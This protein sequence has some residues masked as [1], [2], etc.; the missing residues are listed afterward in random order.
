[1]PGTPFFNIPYVYQL[2]G[3]LNIEALEKALSEIMCRHEAIHTIFPPVDGQ[4]IQIIKP[5]KASPWDIVDLR[6]FTIDEAN[7]HATALILEQSEMPFDLETGPLIRIKLL[8]CKD[9]EHLL[10]IT[11]HHIIVDQASMRIFR[12]ELCDLYEAFSNGGTSP[13]PDVSLG[14]AD[15][16]LWE[17]EAMQNGYFKEV[18]MYWQKQLSLPLSQLN[19]KSSRMRK[20]SLSFTTFDEPIEFEKE[21]FS[22][23]KALARHEHCT[24][25]MI[26]LT[27]ITVVLYL[28]T[29]ENDIR[30][31]TLFS[32]R[33]RL[34]S[35]GIIGHLVNTVVLR[36][37]V[38]PQLTYSQLLKQVRKVVLEAHAHAELPFEVLA[39]VLETDKGAKRNSLIQVLFH[40]QHLEHQPLKLCGLNVA[41]LQTRGND[42]DISMRLTA[43]DLVFN[44]R[45][46]STDIGG[47]VNFATN[48]FS[49]SD[50]PSLVQCFARILRMVVFSPEYQISSTI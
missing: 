2:N 7:E 17:R 33:H 22:G 9:T 48:V 18:L 19:F 1:M 50:I 35:E 15:F 10:L 31:G 13:L 14:F 41:P 32:N 38:N 36:M 25:F 45:E 29:G 39:S 27:A 11:I 49:K 43:F 46:T 44:I 30:I 42:Q 21:L 3:D 8:R 4:P 40:Y 16:A 20:R 34:E 37:L 24:P 23:V 5:V 12:R 6:A 26:V 28:Q 47:F